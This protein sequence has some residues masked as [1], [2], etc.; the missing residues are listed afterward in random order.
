MTRYLTSLFLTAVA[1]AG[2]AGTAPA[3]AVERIVNGGFENT[4]FGATSGYYNL[5]TGGDNHAVP[6]DF[7]FSVPVN[8]VDIVAN[9]VYGPALAGGG[10]YNLDLVGYGST[11]A[12]AQSIRTV[13]GATYKVSIAY[14]SNNGISGPTADVTFNGGTIGLV[15]GTAA[16][17]TFTTT[18]TGTGGF[19]TFGINETYGANNGGVFLDNV[20]VSGAVPEPAT[21][22]L[23][24]AGFGMTGIAAR[25]RKG[26]LAA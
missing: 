5:G 1:V 17:Q 15:T 16:W 14:S 25:R 4:G 26:A 12:I 11:G 8:N 20:S 2:I 22:A 9:G 10:A 18:F 23:L 7:G 24:L 21:W 6:P 3:R 19:A 13:A